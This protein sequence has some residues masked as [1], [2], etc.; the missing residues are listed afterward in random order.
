MC[1]CVC[2]HKHTNK[3]LPK[4][5]N[6]IIDQAP[7]TVK[8]E[9]IAACNAQNVPFI[10]SHS[11]TA[12]SHRKSACTGTFRYSCRLRGHDKRNTA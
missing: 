8:T 11:R 1:V 5:G 2:V 10:V 7:M 4:H 3:E 6:S 9:F 12:L